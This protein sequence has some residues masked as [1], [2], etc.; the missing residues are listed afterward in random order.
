M[1]LNNT[2]LK[3]LAHL[4][5]SG[6]DSYRDI[7]KALK[8]SPAT[9]MKRV[10]NLEKEGF[11]KNYIAVIDYGKLGYDIHVIVDVRVAKGKLHQIENKIARHPNV[12]AVYDNTGPFDATVIARFRTTATMDGF[13]KKLQ[14]YD[15]VMRTE[16]KLILSTISKKPLKLV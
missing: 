16:T 5:K 14:K 11:I 2:D 15:F 4:Q 6:R 3:I 9:V 8:L 1:D 10:K 13:L 12:M 7:A